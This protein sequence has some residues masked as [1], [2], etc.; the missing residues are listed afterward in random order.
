MARAPIMRRFVVFRIVTLSSL[1]FLGSVIALLFF[2]RIE[3]HVTAYGHVEPLYPE[4]V[5]A[6]VPGV[7]L[8]RCFDYG[9]VAKV[10]NIVVRLDDKALYDQLVRQKENLEKAE[11]K[12]LSARKKHEVLLKNPLP[13]KFLVTPEELQKAEVNVARTKKELE[14]ADGLAKQG[15]LATAEVDRANS[16]YQAAL[17]DLKMAQSRHEIVKAGLG[18]STIEASEAEIAVLEKD[19]AS[20]QRECERLQLDVNRATV[21]SPVNGQ[22]VD[23]GV[24]EG[25]AVKPGDVLF[26]MTT[27]P[28]TRLRLRVDEES[29]IKV[30]K[31]QFVWIYSSAFSYRKYGI[32][33]GIVYEIAQ[34]P[35]ERTSSGAVTKPYYEVKVKV[36]ESPLPLPLGSSA[37]GK[38]V[39]A[40]KTILELLLGSD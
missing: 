3:E 16:N 25:E 38:I 19:V 31:E 17:A 8:K 32:G 15:L 34:C 39:V 24:C 4:E 14:V 26:V 5:R 35:P 13:E 9:E 30:G 21:R 2:A 10:G 6:L 40:H 29:I 23:F 1:L 7:V 11:A 27:G 28:E 36:T 37:Q 20:I 33:E 22:I 18:N 12:L